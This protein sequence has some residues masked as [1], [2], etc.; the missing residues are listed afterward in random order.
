MTTT[1]TIER[2]QNCLFLP[3]PYQ[4]L[5]IIIS[6]N[7]RVFAET[8]FGL[9]TQLKLIGFRHV[10]VLHDFSLLSMTYIQPLMS[11]IC[12]S[13]LLHISLDPHDIQ[14]FGQHFI[15][16]HME[17]PWSNIT[18]G[19]GTCRYEHILS[20]SLRIWSFSPWQIELFTNASANH[21]FL[22]RYAA[23]ELQ[24][25]VIDRDKVDYVP[26]Y[27]M[28]PQRRMK[29]LTTYSSDQTFHDL[30]FFGSGSPRR[31]PMLEQLIG[32][33][34]SEGNVSFRIFTGTWNV[35]VFD[36]DRDI[37]VYTAKVIFNINNAEDSVLEAHRLNYLLSMGKCIVSER[38][39]DPLL[40]ARY[41]GAIVFVDSLEE[42]FQKS[43][44]Y[45]KHDK[46]RK[47]IEKLALIRHYELQNDR[48][49]LM[50]AMENVIADLRAL[51][52]SFL[53][54]S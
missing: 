51:D 33:F 43:V 40:A 27:T 17:Q 31:A 21:A 45:A 5:F 32:R 53:E 44:Y 35:T 24:M 1:T 48:K 29:A 52:Q 39:N 7:L 30:L 22:S 13:K 36:L 3:E 26:L 6:Y 38:G 42:L 28:D 10:L 47:D 8:A 14:V 12:G 9:Q 49:D 41:E 16:Y 50:T 19:W 11:K 25:P 15:A 2:D 4:Q 20:R 37:V 18:F 34:H 23:V 54:S 46:E